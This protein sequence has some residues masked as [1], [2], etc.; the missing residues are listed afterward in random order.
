MEYPG[1][2]LRKPGGRRRNGQL[3]TEPSANGSRWRDTFLAK[4]LKEATEGQ[5]G[6]AMESATQ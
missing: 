4:G 1:R 5:G 3:E 2:P 6:G